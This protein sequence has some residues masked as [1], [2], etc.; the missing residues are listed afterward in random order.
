M[1]YKAQNIISAQ[2]I[3]LIMK[4]WSRTVIQEK[5]LLL[6]KTK[7]AWDTCQKE[8]WA[9]DNK[10]SKENV[11]GNMVK[12]QGIN[13]KGKKPTEKGSWNDQP[14]THIEQSLFISIFRFISTLMNIFLTPNSSLSYHPPRSIS[15]FLCISIFCIFPCNFHSLEIISIGDTS[16]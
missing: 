16:L 15:Y 2:S 14:H 8:K 9:V 3:R 10:E 1:G 12:A 6:F 4:E 5:L 7:T 13:I 11:G